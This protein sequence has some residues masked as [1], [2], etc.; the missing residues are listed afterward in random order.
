ME[1][2]RNADFLLPILIV[3]FTGKYVG[4]IF[5]VAIVD[6]TIEGNHMP[7]VETHPPVGYEQIMAKEVMATDLKYFNVV[8][9]AYHIYK[10][11]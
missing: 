4:D 8:D 11:L 10:T 6:I 7:F 2:T 1:T 5:G 3:C 9:N